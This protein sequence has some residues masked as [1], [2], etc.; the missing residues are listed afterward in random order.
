MT[1]AAT[2]FALLAA[3]LYGG[4][5]VLSL[6]R[7]PWS[8]ETA[9]A[10]LG[11]VLTVAWAAVF[12]SH[13][14]AAAPALPVFETARLLAWTLFLSV[15]MA[16]T[17]NTH[18]DPRLRRVMLATPGVVGLAV[19]SNDILTALGGAGGAL[20]QPQIIGREAMAIFGLLLV[21]NLY[22]NTAARR[23]WNAVPLCIALGG[24]FAY[25]LFLY[26]DALLFG[27]VSDLFSSVRPAVC[28]FIAPFL[29]L[30]FMR[31]RGWKVAVHLS[32]SVVLHSL[33]LVASGLFLL[34]IVTVA[35]LLRGNEWGQVVQVT[36]LFGAILVLASIVSSGSIKARLKY[37]IARH[38][39]AQRYDY[40]VEW[41]NFIDLLSTREAGEDLKH[42]AIEGIANVVEAPAGA[43]WLRDGNRANGDFVP[44]SIWNMRLPSDAAEPAHSDF[45]KGFRGGRWI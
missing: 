26:S 3:V 17:I 43:L 19:V 1:T 31:N 25:Q 14:P 6:S 9:L 21:E 45:I 8:R 44:V 34:A 5:L 42:R 12:A 32:Q 4:L 38:F 15:L 18:F 20:T 40:R 22:R 39:F 35:G 16:K 28:C 41:M 37:L 10:S 23:H 24:L 7:R 33:T 27:W 30:T 11:C 2:V 29:A 36:A 13:S